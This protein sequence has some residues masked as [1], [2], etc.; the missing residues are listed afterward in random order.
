MEAKNMR[1]TLAVILMV[2]VFRTGTEVFATTINIPADQPTIQAGIDAAIDG[3]SVMVAPGTYLENINLSGKRIVLTSRYAL[4]ADPEIIHNTVINGGSPRHHDTASVVLIINGEGRQTVVQGFT[5]T[6]GTGTVWPDPHIGGF[7]REG[8]GILSEFSSPTIQ[9]NIIIDNEAIEV[10]TGVTSA[11][12]GG[13]RAGDGNPLIRNNVIM[14]NR[15]R[16]G[17]GVVLNFATG[18]IRN[19]VI[20]NNTGGDDYAGSGLWKYEGG[21]ALVQNNTIAGN[22]S[23]RPGGG[24]YVSATTMTLRNNIIWGNVAPS[25]PQIRGSGATVTYCDVEGGY[26]GEGNLD[27]DPLLAGLYLYLSPLSPCIDAGDWA[28]AYFD[29]E[30]SGNPGSARWPARGALR[31]DMGAY[32]GQGGFDLDPDA[33]DDG[34]PN[35]GD[36]CLTEPNPTQD[37][38]DGDGFGD[39]CDN[40]PEEANPLQEDEDGD[41]IGDVCDICPIDPLNDVDA[42]GLC[43]DA[44]NCPTDYNPGQTDTD[45]DSF[46]DACDNCPNVYNA[47]QEDVDGDGIG[48]SC[49]VLRIWYVQADGMGDAPTI[50]A[51]VDSCTHGDT[52]MVADGVYIGEGNGAIDFRGRRIFITSE[53][54]PEYAII[55]AQGRASEPRRVFAFDDDQD[56]SFVIDGLTIRGG[57]GPVFS[58]SP[59]GGGMLIDQASPTIKNCVFTQNEAVLGGAVFANHAAPRL[60]NCT[61]VGNS[62]YYGSA[63]LAFNNST[64]IMENCIMAFNQLSGPVSCFELSAVTVTCS[65]SFGN[66]G[67]NWSGC[68]AGQEGI[69][70]NISSDPLLCDPNAGAF[71]LFIDS[72]CAP[73]NNACAVLIGAVDVR[74]TCDCGVWGDTNADTEINPVD[75][76]YMVNFVYKNQDARVAPPNCPYDPGDVNCDDAVNPVDI[77]Y[78]VNYVYKDLRPFPCSGCD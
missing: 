64:V 6:G 1:Q 3:D 44:D 55:D 21:D 27:L 9:H 33:D 57:Y 52:V 14:N 78:Y 39:H 61:F 10:V 31:N 69:N 54:G 38:T 65:N 7:Y 24:V 18:E 73:A 25:D 46:G 70:G 23:A 67:N 40:C 49:E 41:G 74:C 68:L 50:Q 56:S 36:N 2:L 11:G 53:N 63:V 5:I 72:P 20:A 13:I 59:S 4:D 34:V 28:P 71:G 47:D 22:I 12:G 66:S 62:A 45:G 58:G 48:D 16:Y 75:V 17:A 60:I 42:D 32:G 37:D 29:V 19:N 43:A 51:A 15:G 30:D 26:A 8:G 76:V 77:V 35:A